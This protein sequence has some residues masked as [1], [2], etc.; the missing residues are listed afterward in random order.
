MDVLIILTLIIILQCIGLSNHNIIY[1]ILLC[2]SV[3]PQKIWT[4]VF[5]IVRP[6]I[7]YYQR[8]IYMT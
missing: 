5:Y 8:H 7:Q 3:I 2:L 4:K 1:G 6:Y